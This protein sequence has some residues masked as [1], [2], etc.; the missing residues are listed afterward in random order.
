MEAG[1]GPLASRGWL[2]TWQAVRRR[3]NVG[4][5]RLAT[6]GVFWAAELK[7]RQCLG[8]RTHVVWHDRLAPA[9]PPFLPALP[10]RGLHHSRVLASVERLERA[11][12][13]ARR[14]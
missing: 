10:G 13:A 4:S 6:L 11:A 5:D 1:L 2:L 12:R 9:D 3:L 7:A 14:E 8:T